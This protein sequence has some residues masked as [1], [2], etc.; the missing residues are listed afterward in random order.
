MKLEIELPYD[1]V[2]PLLSMYPKMGK[3]QYMEDTSLLLCSF[4]YVSQQS[5][6]RISFSAHQRMNRER[7]FICRKYNIPQHTEATYDL[8]WY[9]SFSCISNKIELMTESNTLFEKHV[10]ALIKDPFCQLYYEICI[11]L[12]SKYLFLV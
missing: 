8:Y 4:Q 7:K 5:R 1:T 2:M 3:H 6:C 9:C 12:Y 11:I 10:L